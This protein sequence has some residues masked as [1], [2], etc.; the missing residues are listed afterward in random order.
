LSRMSGPVR[1]RWYDPTRGTFTSVPSSPLGNRG[2]R[3]F[4]PP[5][6]NGGGDEDWVLV[7]DR[8]R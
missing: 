4:T 5:G 7:L 1:A 2:I 3:S 8:T 6:K